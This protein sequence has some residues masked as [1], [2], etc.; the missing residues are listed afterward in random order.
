MRAAQEELSTRDVDVN[1]VS[2]QRAARVRR[3]LIALAVALGVLAAL[4]AGWAVDA[5]GSVTPARTQSVMTR[6]MGLSRVT[7]TVNKP[8]G[9]SQALMLRVTDVSGAA[10]EGARLRCD[11]SMPDMA[12]SLPSVVATR[13]AL[14]GLYECQAPA[15]DP[16]AWSLALTLSLPSG[17]TDHASFAFVT[18]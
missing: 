4:V 1:H 6:Q 17:E 15:L 2:V 3:R 16:G 11:L 8:S 7:L 5:V 12:M 14:P 9:A 10:V 18:G 13:S